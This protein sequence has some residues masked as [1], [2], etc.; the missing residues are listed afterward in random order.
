VR[1]PR[2]PPGAPWRRSSLLWIALVI[3]VAAAFVDARRREIPDA[4]PLVLVAS[5]VAGAALGVVGWP[6]VAAGAAIGFTLGAALFA[7]GAFAGGDAKLLAGLGACLGPAPLLAALLPIAL[8]GGLLAALAW[9]RGA[10]EMAYGPAIALGL[11]VH[12]ALMEGQ[13][14]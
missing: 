7:L 11:L 9:W 1:P 2:R 6:A 5:G 12:A 3:A 10:R 14:A 13:V 8:A 4:F